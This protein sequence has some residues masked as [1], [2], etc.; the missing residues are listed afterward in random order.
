VVE[1]GEAQSRVVRLPLRSQIRQVLLDG[2]ISGRWRPGDRIVER[3]V[4]VEFDVSQAPVR[5]ALRELEALRLVTSVPNKGARVR[6]IELDDLM[7]IYP[8]RASLE[9][10]AASLAVV[11]LDGDVSE[12]QRHADSIRKAADKDDVAEQIRAGVA[13]HRAIVVSSGNNLLLSVWDSLGIEIWT[14]LSIRMFRTELHENADDH[15][16]IVDAFANRDPSIDVLVRDHVM[17][18]CHGS[19]RT[20]GHQATHQL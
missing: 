15:G 16:P 6:N 8:V 18:Y 19:P 7:E 13:F 2:L 3:Q 20:P 12:L 9:G 17:S 4:A 1:A 5:E 10:L 11:R 14:N